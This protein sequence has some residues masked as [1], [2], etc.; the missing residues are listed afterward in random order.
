MT[1]H[2]VDSV[3]PAPGAGDGLEIWDIMETRGAPNVGIP[4]GGAGPTRLGRKTGSPGD[5]RAGEP[6]G[7]LTRLA[8]GNAEAGKPGWLN[9]VGTPSPPMGRRIVG[10]PSSTSASLRISAGSGDSGWFGPPPE[11]LR[12]FG[13]PA[14]VGSAPAGPL[15]ESRET[16]LFALR[17]SSPPV[18][19]ASWARK[20]SFSSIR[21]AILA[22]SF[23]G[24]ELLPLQG[25]RDFFTRRYV[26]FLY[27]RMR[28]MMT[29]NPRTMT[30][31]MIGPAIQL[32]FSDASV[33]MAATL[34]ASGLQMPFKM[35]C[36]G[37]HAENG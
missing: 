28:T 15:P 35:S 10:A 8:P 29:I 16:F 1:T 32:M 34:A 9:S 18:R 14:T 24:F 37:A 3:A 4:M 23:F 6:S 11:V 19:D 33:E 27:F 2:A 5:G 26:S 30:P 7:L 22:D 21:A 20:L 13:R 17:A 36:P 31:A 25:T 12:I